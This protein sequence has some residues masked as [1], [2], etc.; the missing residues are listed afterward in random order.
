VAP[1]KGSFPER[2]AHLS[3]IAPLVGALLLAQGGLARGALALIA[4][5]GAGGVFAAVTGLRHAK[6]NSGRGRH[7]ARIG[8]IANVL[9]LA[10]VVAYYS[11]AG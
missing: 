9:F 1:T 2:A 4:L 5:I 11:L 10:A 3:Y 8:L 7:A 6:A